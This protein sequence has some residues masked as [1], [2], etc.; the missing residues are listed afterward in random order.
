MT[1][2]TRLISVT[3]LGGKVTARVRED[4]VSGRYKDGEHLT[5]RDISDEVRC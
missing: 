2:G 1:D 4:I 3:G 5:E